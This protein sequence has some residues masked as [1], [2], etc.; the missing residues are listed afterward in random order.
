[1]NP[2]PF[3]TSNHLTL[4]LRVEAVLLKQRNAEIVVA[5]LLDADRLL[6]TKGTK[7]A[8]NPRL[9]RNMMFDIVVD[10]NKP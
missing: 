8:N 3:L 10:D 9:E 6:W 5:V 4:P 2:N 1:M 7:R